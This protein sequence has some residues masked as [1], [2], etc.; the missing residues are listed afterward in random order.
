MAEALKIPYPPEEPDMGHILRAYDPLAVEKQMKQMTGEEL[1][2]TGDI[3]R[4]ELIRGELIRM[5]P[6][7]Y[8]HGMVESR[9]GAVLH[10]SVTQHHLGEVLV[11]EV[12]IYTSRNPDTVRGADVIYISNERLSQVKSKSY[13]DVAPELIV[14]V[15]S[16]RDRW[17]DVN[18]KLSEYFGIG[19]RIIWI[20]D[21]R[22]RQVF[23]YESATRSECLT[24]DKE[25]SEGEILP[26]FRVRVSELF[27][28][29]RLPEK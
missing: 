28:T 11:G 15:L 3:G 12:G 25:L 4:S 14:E 17:T 29:H 9:F 24:A 26:G 18:E 1:F 5:S 10:N 27:G 13:L 16:P 8:L 23:V 7:G 6:T 21:P 20:V 2:T 19:V 22:R